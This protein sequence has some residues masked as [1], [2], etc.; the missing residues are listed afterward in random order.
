LLPK[1][2]LSIPRSVVGFFDLDT[3]AINNR[4]SPYALYSG[5]SDFRDADFPYSLATW[6]LLIGCK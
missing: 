5:V 6:I 2:F 4:D 3:P 1:R